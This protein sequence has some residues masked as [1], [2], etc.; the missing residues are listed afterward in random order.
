MKN[1]LATLVLIFATSGACA[2]PMCKDSIANDEGTANSLHDSYTSNGQNI[3]GGIN[4][5]VYTMLAV[6]L[7]MMGLVSTVIVKGVRGSDARRGFPIEPR[8]KDH[9]GPSRS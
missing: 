5:S 4:A 1:L 9:D 6:L 2:C 3:S 8:G 7:G